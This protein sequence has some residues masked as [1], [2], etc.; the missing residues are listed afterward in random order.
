MAVAVI[1]ARFHWTRSDVLALPASE[2]DF[3]LK[4]CLKET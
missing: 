1:S 3:Y 2:F 4:L